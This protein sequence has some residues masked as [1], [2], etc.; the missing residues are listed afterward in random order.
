[1]RLLP[2]R[3]HETTRAATLLVA[4]TLGCCVAIAQQAVPLPPASS[5][6]EPTAA[7]FHFVSDGPIGPGWSR[8]DEIAR[9]YFHEQLPA[10]FTRTLLLQQ[11]VPIDAH[12]VWIFTGPHAGFTVELIANK[13]RLYQRYYDSAGLY[14]GQGNYPQKIV[15]DEERQFT[16]SATTLTVTTDSHLSVTVLING[17]PMI[18][19]SCVF[20]VTRHQLMLSAPR[21]RHLVVE[22]ALLS[23]KPV[24]AAVTVHADEKHQT[25]LG[26]G[27]SPSIPAYAALSDA[28][29]AQYWKI[30]QQYNL[31][32]HREYPAGSTLKPDLSNITDLKDATPHYYGDNFP[33]GE[34]SSF[35]YSRHIQQLGGEVLYEV[36]ALP[37]WAQVEYTA[38]GK[39]VV[40]TWNK[41]V[42]K[43]ADPEKYAA[44][45]IGYCK[46]ALAET[47]HAPE[48]VGVQNEVDE[49]TE[50]FAAMTTT[51]RRRLDEAGFKDTKIQMADAS[52][53]Y[54][55]VDRAKA[56]QAYRDAWKDTDFIAAHQ[57]DYQQFLANPDM[58]DERLRAMH[59]ASDGK[60][61]LATEICLN[62]P[63]YQESSYRLAFAVA[64]L[65]YKDL[66]ELDAEALLYCWILLDVEQPNFGG[67]RSLLVPD[68]TNS[69]MPVAS[70]FQLR[71]LG[72]FS[73]YIRTGM[74]RV[75]VDSNQPDLLVTGYKDAKDVTLVLLNRSTQAE[76]VAVAW[77]DA[78]WNT[79]ERTSTYAANQHEPY[80]GGKVTIAP[81]EILT[82]STLQ[83]R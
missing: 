50:V 62:D 68:R 80:A 18:T 6:S 23:D 66:T 53:L 9:E 67:S 29:K 43:V 40:D 77:P 56:L 34:I 83:P 8:P 57:Y 12:L 72:A 60:P 70:S 47:G 45:M 69:G 1:M 79:I 46:K 37:S 31:L 42:H 21:S 33:N 41:P 59:A 48:M 26:F 63:H 14:D 28:G 54:V 81:G 4:L 20:D 71:A 39:P 15:R 25:M 38:A 5:T 7:E 36:W 2:H 11:T 78:H 22:G 52:Y 76:Q 19:Q 17:V 82:L 10:F 35:E 73:R 64:Q 13:V 24:S 49:P 65:Y 27:G 61:F 32:I 44:I 3:Q 16:G 58:Y 74:A 51:L 55:G 75:S 30:V